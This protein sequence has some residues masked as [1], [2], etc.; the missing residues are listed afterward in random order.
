V[1]LIEGGTI[2]KE[3]GQGVVETADVPQ[4]LANCEGSR[5]P[6]G[7]GHMVWQH[8]RWCMLRPFQR[9]VCSW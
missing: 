2:Y 5:V 8:L 3:E 7:G 9:W 1:S 6:G 4:C